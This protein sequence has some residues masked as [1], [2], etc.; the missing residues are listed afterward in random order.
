[1]KFSLFYNR[2]SKIIKH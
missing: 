1:M 2:S